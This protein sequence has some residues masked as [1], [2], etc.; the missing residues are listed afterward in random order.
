MRAW[1]YVVE[2]VA[3]SITRDPAEETGAFIAVWA[4]GCVAP[5]IDSIATIANI[6]PSA[7]M[8]EPLTFAI[9]Q[10]GREISASLGTFVL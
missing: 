9:Y 4:A 2:E 5:T 6:T 10:Q 1:A 3:P 8:F 7:Q